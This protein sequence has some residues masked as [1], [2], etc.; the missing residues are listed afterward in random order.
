MFLTTLFTIIFLAKR[1]VRNSR[2]MKN[3]PD[4]CT[5]STTGVDT[6]DS[7]ERPMRWL[8]AGTFL[9]AT[10]RYH[11]CL[12]YRSPADRQH[13]LCSPPKIY[14][15]FQRCEYSTTRRR[16][17]YGRHTARRAC[18]RALHAHGF[19]GPRVF[20]F[21]HNRPEVGRSV[22]N[23]AKAHCFLS[24]P[25]MDLSS[26]YTATGCEH[27]LPTPTAT[28]TDHIPLNSNRRTPSKCFSAVVLYANSNSNINGTRST[29]LI[30]MRFTDSI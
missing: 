7:T 26:T 6:N 4:C 29:R 23:H 25:L 22:P 2:R 16:R 30:Q 15:R 28:A 24:V 20:R 19:H 9:H 3:E 1:V 14:R 17:G 5:S 12:P 10:F 18:D 8:I 27:P 11:F 21:G 13:R